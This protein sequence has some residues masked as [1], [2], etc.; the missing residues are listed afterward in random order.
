M[1]LV[2][3]SIGKCRHKALVIK[4]KKYIC[5]MS[6]EQQEHEKER[7]PYVTI[8]MLCTPTGD[9]NILICELFYMYIVIEDHYMWSSML[10]VFPLSYKVSKGVLSM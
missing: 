3:I 9:M 6:N 10:F 5:V 2:S 1:F 7:V 8:F 4:I